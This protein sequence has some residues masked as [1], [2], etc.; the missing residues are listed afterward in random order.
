MGLPKVMGLRHVKMEE[1]Y[2]VW[3]TLLW[4]HNEHISDV[5]YSM[6]PQ[7]NRQDFDENVVERRCC[8]EMQHISTNIHPAVY[9]LSKTTPSFWYHC[10]IIQFLTDAIL[11][12]II[13]GTPN[14][15]FPQKTK[16][17]ATDYEPPLTVGSGLV[18]TGVG[19]CTNKHHPT[20]G[21]SYP[22]NIC[23]GDVK[24]T[25]KKDKTRDI[26]Q[27]LQGGAPQLARLVCKSYN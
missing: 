6:G 22:T 9:R 8:D 21:D 2:F 4:D 3:W 14:R 23:F 19:K 18:K 1:S 24:Q 5:E 7:V 27:S 15:Q 12:W 10:T 11:V 17:L 20:I 25:P 16:A 13:H 26:Y